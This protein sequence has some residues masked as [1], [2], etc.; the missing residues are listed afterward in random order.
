M[1]GREKIEFGN[2]VVSMSALSGG[3][4]GGGGEDG[5]A[6]SSGREPLRRPRVSTPGTSR[7]RQHPERGAPGRSQ[8]AAVSPA[9]KHRCPLLDI[10]ARRRPWV[11][12]GSSGRGAEQSPPATTPADRFRVSAGSVGDGLRAVGVRGCVAAGAG[13]RE[14]R[15]CPPRLQPKFVLVFGK[16]RYFPVFFTVVLPKNKPI[17]LGEVETA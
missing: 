15:D 2:R 9:P 5:P 14:K 6:E 12:G 4:R 17:N 7:S 1:D 8:A 3:R 11:R 13:E 10:T 16:G